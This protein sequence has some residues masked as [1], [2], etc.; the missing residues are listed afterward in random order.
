MTQTRNAPQLDFEWAT[1][2]A[3]AEA[4][5]LEKR[6]FHPVSLNL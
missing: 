3:D 5:E 4:S 6:N 2:Y 1:K